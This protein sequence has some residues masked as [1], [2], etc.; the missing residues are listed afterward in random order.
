MLN[1]AFYSLIPFV[2]QT[3]ETHLTE[4]LTV[5]GHVGLQQ[6]SGAV[7]VMGLSVRAPERL[8]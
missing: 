7:V 3:C 6:V 5:G 1:V 4:E 8:S 2:Y